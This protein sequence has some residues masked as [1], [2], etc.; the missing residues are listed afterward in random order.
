MKVTGFTFVRNALKFDYPVVESILSILPICDDFVVSVGNSDDDTLSLIKNIESPKIRIVESVWD[1]TLR[2][3]GKVLSIET[4]K[5]LNK[6][7]EDTDWA[8]YIQADE[9][10]HENDLDTIYDEMKKWKDTAEVDGL[11]FKYRHFYGSYDY[12]GDSVRWYRREIRTIKP[13]RNIYSYGDA[14][15]FRKNDDEKLNVKLINAYINHYGWVKHPRHMQNKQETFNKLWHDD[16]WL[17]DN[18]IKAEE[19]DFSNIDSLTLFD[20]THPNVMEERIKKVNWKFSHD[21]SIK[22]LSLKN[23]IR[24]YI[25]KKTGWRP[26]EYKNYR[27]V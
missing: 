5:S 19:F 9:V 4:N 2:E 7:S 27:L 18:I 10:V 22:K 14:Q 16:K 26:G 21:I 12:T 8:F 6:V 25:E 23:T 15:G 3:G 11:L 24:R 17:D 13:R 20:G 1:D